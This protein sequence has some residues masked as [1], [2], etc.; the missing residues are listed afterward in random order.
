[1]LFVEH[2][3]STECNTPVSRVY[4]KEIA[5]F[6]NAAQAVSNLKA[7]KPTLSNLKNGTSYASSLQKRTEKKILWF[8]IALATALEKEKVTGSEER[9]ITLRRKS[10]GTREKPKNCKHK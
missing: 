9:R 5:T 2:T 7:T 4:S 1:M 10:Q 6:E 8:T 3:K